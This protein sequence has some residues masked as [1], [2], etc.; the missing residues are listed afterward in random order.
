MIKIVSL[1]TSN[2]ISAIEQ[3]IRNWG[4]EFKFSLYR[5]LET[6][7]KVLSPKDVSNIKDCNAYLI[8][9]TWGST[10]PARQKYKTADVER[11][12]YGVLIEDKFV[13][14]AWMEYINT[15][16]NLLSKQYN[17]PLLVT[18]SATLSR[19]KCNHIDTWYKRTGPRYYRMSLGHWTYG[20]G[21]WCQV[22]DD[23][24]LN[25]LIALTKQFHQDIKLDNIYNHQ[26]KNNKDGAV[27]IVPGLE[28]DPTSTVPVEDFIKQSVKE[29]R[30]IT[31]RKILI[32]PHPK[33]K[34]D[35]KKLVKDVEV[36]PNETN[37][38]KIKD[39]IY[40]AVISESTS[41]FQLINLGIPCITSK[42]SFGYDIS[43]SDISKLENL[44]LASSEEVYE[45]YKRISYTEFTD[46][47]FGTRT[48]LPYIK[49]LLDE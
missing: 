20:K 3:A 22:K 41:I 13:R 26:W 27:L 29:I 40:C 45:W 2:T 17:K 36:V 7:N 18:E 33:S 38:N 43:L 1:G 48:I 24:R 14:S 8:D 28:Y 39:R 21:K 5:I 49:E 11:T 47:E 44:Y 34:I 46:E 10:N 16:A 31:Q 37:F 12:K 23:S 32:K 35:I 25:N 9:G 15:Q 6:Q 19:I 42:Y 4:R 30:K